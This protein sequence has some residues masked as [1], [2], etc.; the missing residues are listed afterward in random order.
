MPEQAR[1]KRTG[2]TTRATAPVT[3]GTT[4]PVATGGPVARATTVA[5]ATDVVVATPPTPPTPPTLP[6]PSPRLGVRVNATTLE[7]AFLD[8][9]PSRSVALVQEVLRARGF[10]PGDVTGT[11]NYATRAAY[12]A[13]Q[14]T[15]NERPTG[16][17][18]V[19]SL[20]H[21]GLDV[22]G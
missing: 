13:Y 17:P 16:L 1:G 9:T 12:A 7:N 19:R 22:V 10:D 21:L 2:A 5:A 20:D 18:T 3:V 15:I 8:A 6:E 4:S 11:V 14:R